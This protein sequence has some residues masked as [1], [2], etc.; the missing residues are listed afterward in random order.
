MEKIQAGNMVDRITL[1]EKPKEFQKVTASLKEP[2]K[3]FSDLILPKELPSKIKLL[4]NSTGLSE[5]NTLIR[6]VIHL[7]EITTYLLPNKGIFIL[8]EQGTGKSTLFSSYFPDLYKKFSGAITTPSL[9]GSGNISDESKIKES[10]V[11]LDEKV[12]VV[13]EFTNENEQTD[14]STTGTLKDALES[15]NFLKC[16]KVETKTE[17]TFI[18]IGNSYAPLF[19]KEELNKIKEVIPSRYRDRALGDRFPFVLPHF[20]TLFGKTKYVESENEVLPIAYLEQILEAL[21]NRKDSTLWLNMDDKREI[22]VF[23][24]FINAVSTLCYPNGSAPEWFISGWLEFFKFFRS[25]LIDEEI[26]NPFN[27][28]SARFIVSMLGYSIDDIDYVTFSNDRIL[29]KSC[30]ENKIAKVALTGFGVK[31]NM[32]EYDF[33][34]HT[35]LKEIAPICDFTKDFLV[36]TQDIQGDLP[37]E[38]RVY[39]NNIR[40]HNAEVKDKKDDRYNDLILNEIERYIKEDILFSKEKLAFRG[41]PEFIKISIP[42]LLSDIFK[43]KID[44]NDINF[45]DISFNEGEIQIINYIN[46][47]KKN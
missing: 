17:T 32:L 8:G 39:F 37:F 14:S 46:F 24:P 27:E 41:I 35:P 5:N 2:I 45:N 28:K 22:G 42:P 26:Y 6:K 13:E 43:K 36:L 30:V 19:S 12:V 3:E 10:K 29:I 20:H 23:N 47:L 31:E 15:G 9:I 33:Y 44:I 34:K 38:N 40:K 25:I 4:M 16:K 1:R 21:R 11:L 18:F 7:T